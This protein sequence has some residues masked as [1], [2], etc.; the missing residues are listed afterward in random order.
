MILN[1]L[2]MIT[3]MLPYKYVKC[4][5]KSYC[6]QNIQKIFT[7]KFKIVFLKKEV[8]NIPAAM[9]DTWVRTDPDLTTVPAAQLQSQGHSNS[10]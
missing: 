2:L 7:T 1:L 8:I 4:K 5:S 3:M 10:N 9:T 6:I